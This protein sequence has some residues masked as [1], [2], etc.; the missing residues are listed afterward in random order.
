MINNSSGDVEGAAE[1]TSSNNTNVTGGGIAPNH[2]PS[3]STLPPPPTIMATT[4]TNNTGATTQQQ[5]QQ[6]A[7]HSS[8]SSLPPPPKI[9]ISKTTITSA[10]TNNSADTKS[11]SSKTLLPPPPTLSFAPPPNNVINANGGGSANISKD[12]PTPRTVALLSE[13]NDSQQQQQQQQHSSPL[14]QS[15]H[16]TNEQIPP[17]TSAPNSGGGFDYNQVAT[18]TQHVATTIGQ[19]AQEAVFPYSQ[20]PPKP[21]PV[22]VPALDTPTFGNSSGGAA[23]TGGQ[24]KDNFAMLFQNGACGSLDGGNN[25][26]SGDITN[27]PTTTMTTGSPATEM[28]DS[29][30][31][32]MPS[33]VV[34][35]TPDN[36]AHP[37]VAASSPP[38]FPPPL[39]TEP[40]VV[41]AT[42]AVGGLPPRSSPKRK[43]SS[44]PSR[45]SKA[46]SRQQQQQ[47]TQQR[48]QQQQQQQQRPREQHKRANAQP[49][50]TVLASRQTRHTVLIL[51]TSDAQS[52]ATKNNTTLTELF[53]VFGNTNSSSTIHNN[54]NSRQNRNEL[55]PPL[56]P[57]RSANR[58]MVLQWDQIVLDFVSIQD[59]EGYVPDIE[60]ERALGESACVWDEDRQ[61]GEDDEEL[62]RLETCVVDALKEEE[63]GERL[64]KADGIPSMTS[65]PLSSRTDNDD[66][67]SFP[68]QQEEILKECADTAISLTS[69]PNT[70][71]LLRFRHT[72][73]CST[74]SIGHEMFRNPSV[75]ILAASTAE[76]YINCFAELANVHHLP[77]PYHDGRYDPNGVRR[78]F[79]LLH[80]V[81]N[82]PKDFDEARALQR[83]R[84]RF[85]PGCCQ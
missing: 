38:S 8:Y 54:N 21:P 84:D 65:A 74:D 28:K 11:S 18:F 63:E 26:N 31:H 60:A 29:I 15:I 83:M 24:R 72:L 67:E 64:R 52:I 39:V 71:W 1:R 30:T 57:F 25:N 66:N 20:Y 19:T 59:M 17:L 10:A 23:G 7:G 51:P 43:P 78:E 22:V 42:T 79:L 37:L 35:E 9:N 77:R 48:Q 82:G 62:T 5:H 81:F 32:S 56:P 4:T 36:S 70:P 3:L 58:S 55:E 34:M 40:P 69:R 14:L 68:M 85:G 45:R 50:L 16:S 2:H 41:P 12:G 6:Q 75:V 61:E 33:D 47:P 49:P 27:V 13:M 73:D 53:R 44:S 80:D 46:V 76:P